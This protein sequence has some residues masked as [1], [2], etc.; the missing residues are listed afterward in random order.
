MQQASFPLSHFAG[1]CVSVRNL[2]QRIW[3]TDTDTNSQ[4]STKLEVSIASYIKCL[5]SRRSTIGLSLFKL[6]MVNNKCNQKFYEPKA[7]K[8]VAFLTAVIKCLARCSLPGSDP[9]V[10][11]SLPPARL[12]TS[13]PTPNRGLSVQNVS[14]WG[15]FHTQTITAI[16]NKK[17]NQKGYTPKHDSY[18]E[19]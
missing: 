4:L 2:Q 16:M 6:S 5:H 17:F 10:T 1:P 3:T 9:T 18:T 14:L 7:I 19:P 11:R 8:L 15:T 12:Y 13:R